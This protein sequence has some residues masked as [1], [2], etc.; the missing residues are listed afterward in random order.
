MRGR[1]QLTARRFPGSLRRKIFGYHLCAALLSEEDT[2]NQQRDIDLAGKRYR[3]LV[4]EL[5]Q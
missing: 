4:W 1:F 2:E 3:D 5:A